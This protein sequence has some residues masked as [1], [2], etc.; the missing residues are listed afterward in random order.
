MEFSSRT[1]PFSTIASPTLHFAASHPRLL[2]TEFEFRT[3]SSKWT[4]SV[5]KLWC[6]GSQCN[7]AF[8]C[9]EREEKRKG[10]GSLNLMASFCCP[11]F[12]RKWE[13]FCWYPKFCFIT[14][15]IL[16]PCVFSA[17][18]QS[19]SCSTFHFSILKSNSIAVVYL[20][21]SSR[22]WDGANYVEND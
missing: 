6:F 3:L 4:V 8:G 17:T 5:I 13:W 19:I 1:A 14:A 2:L 9:G 11:S 7:S 21:S 15:R 20:F 22:W 18:K 16:C 12:Q 10:N